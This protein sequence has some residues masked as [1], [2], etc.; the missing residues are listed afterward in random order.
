MPRSPS[1][2]EQRLRREDRF[3]VRAAVELLRRRYVPERHTVAAAVRTRSGRIFRG[4]NLGGI[5]TPCAEPVAIG[6]AI[7]A[8][9]PH[10]EVM[11]AVRRQGRTYPILAPCGTC[12]QLLFDYAPRAFILVRDQATGVR[13]LRADEA[14]PVA[15]STF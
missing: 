5:H 10:L 7:T 13:R 4:V 2:P 15:D 1:E 3:L 9:D 14:L 12:R 6:A 11:V 8:G